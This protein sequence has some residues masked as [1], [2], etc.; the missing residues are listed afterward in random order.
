MALID[1]EIQQMLE[2]EAIHVVRPGRVTLRA[3]ELNFSNPQKR[4]WPEA[5]S[6]SLPPQSVHPFRAFQNGRDSL[7]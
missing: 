3:C 2:K 6:E 5:R 1:L 4:G 7:A